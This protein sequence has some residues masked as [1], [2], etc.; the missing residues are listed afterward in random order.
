MFSTSFLKQ[1]ECAF[2]FLIKLHCFLCFHQL[3]SH[4]NHL[5]FFSLLCS[6]LNCCY[7]YSFFTALHISSSA[8][9]LI[10]SL[11]YA[12]SYG[13]LIL[14]PSRM[15]PFV[16]YSSC[17]FLSVFHFWS[18]HPIFCPPISVSLIN[19]HPNLPRPFPMF[20]I[21]SIKT[22]QASL[23]KPMLAQCACGSCYALCCV[24]LP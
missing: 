17:V 4:L 21:N 19:S 9:F 12:W 11:L 14:T 18:T 24:L 10:S 8:V 22:Q 23:H 7:F 16:Y 5:F 2:S 3:S 1:L 13:F 15:S 20:S 6:H